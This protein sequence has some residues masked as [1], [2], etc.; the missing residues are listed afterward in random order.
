MA[1]AHA[2]LPPCPSLA[3]YLLMEAVLK[4]SE[5]AESK[6]LELEKIISC[7]CSHNLNGL[8]GSVKASVWFLSFLV[9]ISKIEYTYPQ[10]R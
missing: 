3:L 8:Q 2:V 6:H 5:R 10:G 1:S 7:W 9:G 4:V